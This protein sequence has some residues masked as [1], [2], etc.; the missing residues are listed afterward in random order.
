MV[1]K[2]KSRTDYKFAILKKQFENFGSEDIL[3]EFGQ[4]IG[5]I[6]IPFYNPN[7]NLT[8]QD[9]IID[10]AILIKG[11]KSLFY[12][13][14]D[15]RDKT[16]KIIGK[17]KKKKSLIPISKIYIKNSYGNIDYTAVGDFRSWNYEIINISDDKLIA[18]VKRM[19][20]KSS[21][22][23]KLHLNYNNY[24]F[25]EFLNQAI[26]N[27]TII[28]FVIS[29]NNLIY[30]FHGISD[31]AGIERRIARLRPFGPGKSLN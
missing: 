12:K 6:I 23:Q 4:I 26:E 2:E 25:I 7:K 5:K 20:E 16:N 8:I 24:Y 19:N 15:L 10:K 28:G 22:T 17:I 3:N 13:R 27:I 30:K 18:R 29:I 31:I 14:Q 1:L 9:L 11:K 21:I